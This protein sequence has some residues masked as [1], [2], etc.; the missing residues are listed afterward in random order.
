MAHEG[1]GRRWYRQGRQTLQMRTEPGM[2][3]IYEKGMA[4][5]HCRWSGEAG[6]C[7]L[8][9]LADTDV[10]SMTHGDMPF[11]ALRTQHEVFDRRVSHAVFALAG[12][13]LAGHPN[14]RLYAQGLSVALLGLMGGSYAASAPRQ[15]ALASGRLG[16]VQ[17]RLLLDI[18]HAELGADLSLKRLADEI[19]LSPFHFARTF[20][21][22]FGLTPHAY[23][24][25][26]RIKAAIRSLQTDHARSIADIAIASGF[27][28]Q[29]HMT[30][31]M[32][33]KVGATPREIRLG[34]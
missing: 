24:Q 16:A 21:A 20:K 7:V 18:I 6:R 25:E 33:R 4:F 10:Y 8:V 34:T 19:G 2:I 26:C 23:V 32:R 13:A 22:T 15:L 30:E 11:L 27:A 29:S 17:Q 31:L 28:S 9:E 1:R 3:E 12:E 14:G 5:D